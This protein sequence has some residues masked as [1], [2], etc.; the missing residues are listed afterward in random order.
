MTNI[1]TCADRTLVRAIVQ[2]HV[3]RLTGNPRQELRPATHRLIARVFDSIE[4]DGDLAALEVTL[5][6]CLIA[7]NAKLA[8]I[9][10]DERDAK[11]ALG[12]GA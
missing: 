5:S 7:V 11:A 12:E 2:R 8:Q 4:S 6:N 3:S 10:L 1:E 9:K